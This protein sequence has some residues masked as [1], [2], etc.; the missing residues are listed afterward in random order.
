M[1]NMRETCEKHAKATECLIERM[2][3]V[4][5]KGKSM[6]VERDFEKR[7]RL[8][9]EVI[10]TVVLTLLMFLVIHSAV[11]NFN[12]DGHSMEPNLHDRELILVD[13]WTYLFHTPVRGDVIIFIAPPSPSEDY[14]KR[15]IGV[16]GDV[17]TI[18]NGVPIVNGVSL[19]EFYV[20]PH[21][22]GATP[23]DQ[24][25]NKSIVPPDDYF[26]MGDN[27]VG[28]SDSRTWGFVPRSNIIGRAAVVYWPLGQD[29]NGLLPNVSS[30]YAAVHQSR[31]R[32][33]STLAFHKNTVDV[34]EIILLVMPGLF[35]V[36]SRRPRKPR[37]M[38]GVPPK[39][40]SGK[41]E[42]S[43][44]KHLGDMCLDPTIHECPGNG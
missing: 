5:Y 10:E 19:K 13:K 15:I 1:R 31:T 32:A 27:R 9:R 25:I 23:G 36:F 14:V 41:D 40:H 39:L 29:N 35:V 24:S 18:T 17:I 20:D 28:S 43:V 34:N 6:V 11:Q 16:P 2:Q 30:V 26:V 21:R 38:V 33:S 44:A 3:I 37:P 42:G 22:M 12:V 8:L 4:V 7:Y